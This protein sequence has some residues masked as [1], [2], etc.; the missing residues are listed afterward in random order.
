MES[1]SVFIVYLFWSLTQLLRVG[2]RLQARLLPFPTLLPSYSFPWHMRA[3]LFAQ[4]RKR[5]TGAI[6]R[7]FA[8]PLAF[9]N[10]AVVALLNSAKYSPISTTHSTFTSR[11]TGFYPSW[12]L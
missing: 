3:S 2:G 9:P 1:V 8:A 6:E 7:R 4:K 5:R 10:S 11:L 12:M